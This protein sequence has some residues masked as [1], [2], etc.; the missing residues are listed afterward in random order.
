MKISMKVCLVE[1][2]ILKLNLSQIQSQLIQ[3][4]L[5]KSSNTFLGHKMASN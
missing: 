5:T 3:Y 4:N 2:V 1:G